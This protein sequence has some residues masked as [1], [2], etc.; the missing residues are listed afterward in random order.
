M[1]RIDAAVCAGSAAGGHNAATVSDARKKG[2]IAATLAGGTHDG[3]DKPRHSARS[4]GDVTWPTVYSRNSRARFL[5][6]TVLIAA[7]ATA[8]GQAEPSQAAGGRQLGRLN[9]WSAR[10]STGRVLAGSWT[11]S[12]DPK[13]GA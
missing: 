1:S 7:L 8:T 12:V 9:T 10:S 5:L 11:G 2:F 3:D 13:T 6:S 4:I